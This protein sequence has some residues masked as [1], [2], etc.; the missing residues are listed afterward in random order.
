VTGEGGQR[1]GPE[2]DDELLAQCRVDT[3]RAG[4]KGG[5][6]QNTTESGV[7]L[8]HGP[9]GIVVTAR[10]ERSQHRNRKV[11][12]ER[13][14]KRLRQ[15]RRKARKRIPTR[16]PASEKRKRRERKKIR[17]RKKKLRKPPSP[18]D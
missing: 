3:F 4:G 14:R 12:L 10:E 6:H 15:R 5:Q 9:T 8:T 17:G 1:H 13:L 2:S 11:A 16:V 18:D 7:R